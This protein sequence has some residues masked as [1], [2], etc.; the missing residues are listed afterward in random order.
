MT[1]AGEPLAAVIDG[2]VTT[3][4]PV[5]ADHRGRLFEIF[6]GESDFWRSP[7]VYCYCCTIRPLQ[8]KAWGLHL[9]KADRYVVI[10]GEMTVVLYDARTDSPTYRMTQQLTMSP[11]A[12][13]QLLIPVGVWHAD[14]NVSGEE[15]R[16]LNLPTA[17][18]NHDDPDRYMLPWDTDL[19]PFDLRS[20]FPI[21]AQTSLRGSDS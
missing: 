6:T 17:R 14:V 3:A 11:E 13:Q 20:V 10:S 2:V 15:V 9:F 18:Y 8:V 16:F 12:V 7:V 19:I 1:A 5:H 4:Q 21:Q